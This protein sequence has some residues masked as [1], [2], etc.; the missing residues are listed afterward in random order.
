MFILK[1]STKFWYLVKN[2]HAFFIKKINLFNHLIKLVE[3]ITDNP[4]NI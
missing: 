4:G 1:K 3:S 2:K